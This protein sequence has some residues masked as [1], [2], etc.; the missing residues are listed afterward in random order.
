MRKIELDSHTAD[1]IVIDVL[2][3][4]LEYIL[5]CQAWYEADLE[6]RETMDDDIWCHPVD[7]R[8]NRDKYIPALKLIIEYFGG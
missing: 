3:D 6:T 7:Y 1:R 8:D 4:Q 2:K 5:K